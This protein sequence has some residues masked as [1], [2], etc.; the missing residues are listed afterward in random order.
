M[1]LRQ[2]AADVFDSL[3]TG[4]VLR[5]FMQYLI[6]FCSQQDAASDVIFGATVDLVGFDVLLKF[7][8]LSL[9]CSR[10]R[11]SQRRTDERQPTE[12]LA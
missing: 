5:T 11:R 6:I 7:G 1:I 8:D 4:L 10:E 2:T 3:T 12:R 9:N